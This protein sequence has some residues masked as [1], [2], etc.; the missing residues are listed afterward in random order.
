MR[1]SEKGGKP[2]QLV[3][4]KDDE[5]AHGPQ[6]LPGGQAVLFTLAKGIGVADRWDKAQLV[7]HSLKSGETKGSRR[8]GA[9]ARYVPTGHMV[10]AVGGTLFAVPF[11]LAGLEVTGG[12]VPAV[13]GVLRAS[14]MT[15]G[16]VHFSFSNV[17][18]AIY[19]PGSAG[20][21]DLALIDRKGVVESLRLPPSA[22][23]SP[24][25]SP[26]GTRVAIES[27]DGKDAI[28]WVY[29]LAGASAMRR[30]TFGGRNRFPVWSADGPT[31]D[32]SVRSRA[33]PRHLLAARRRYWRDGAS[34]EA[35][36][37]DYSCAPRVGAKGRYAPV[38]A[39]RKD[40]SWLSGRCR[41]RTEGSHRLAAC[42]PILRVR[43]M[44]CFHPMATGWRTR[45][46]KMERPV[47]SSPNHFQRQA[48]GT[49]FQGTGLIRSGRLMERTVLHAGE[50][51]DRCQCQYAAGV[52]LQ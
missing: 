34:H 35:G 26:D 12:P 25:I 16:S 6:M 14:L 30:L 2:E 21:Q 46:P 42:S 41:S 20:Q 11:N 36:T 8:S 51:V 45:L 52:H 18:S 37:G 1:V 24:R 49:R 10:Y 44:P 22:Y 13:E 33:G 40:P 27:D 29:D 31:C 38:S 28:V 50:S 9:D 15:T 32:I 23:E 43:P 39:W 3:S 7:V 4:V 5:L 48:L 17:G 47:A 19:I